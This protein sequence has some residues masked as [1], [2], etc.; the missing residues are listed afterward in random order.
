M[1]DSR[2]EQKIF[3]SLTATMKFSFLR[4]SLYFIV[5]SNHYC[6]TVSAKT[7]CNHLAYSIL[8][9]KP[10]QLKHSIFCKWAMC[11]WRTIFHLPRLKKFS[12]KI[13]PL[14]NKT[15]QCCK[16]VTRILG[17]YLND[18]LLMIQTFMM[19]RFLSISKAIH[20]IF[21]Q[22]KAGIVFWHWKLGSEWPST[23]NVFYERC[24]RNTV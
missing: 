6:C 15:G 2:T 20:V 23:S 22:S 4:W 13:N 8:I 10:M 3:I 9:N 19:G 16:K 24:F 7:N 1:S 11:N 5:F 17:I 18:L 12:T 14:Q 21:F